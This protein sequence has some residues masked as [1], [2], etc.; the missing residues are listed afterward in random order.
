MNTGIR[1]ALLMALIMALAACQRE[2]SAPEPVSAQSANPPIEAAPETVI[3]EEVLE[4]VSVEAEQGLT[5]AE[6]PRKPLNLELD[7]ETL[8]SLSAD[9]SDHDALNQPK[10]SLPNVFN[11]EKP[12][13][14]S[15]LSGK[16]LQDDSITDP[17]DA[18]NGAEVSVEVKTR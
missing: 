8:M 9:D 7:E 3:V 6:P 2:S 15:K 10:Y 11:T 18:I 16:L 4:E 1:S 12:P 17:I 14:R 5:P 13:R